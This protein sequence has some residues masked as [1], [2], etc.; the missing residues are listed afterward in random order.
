MNDRRKS[1]VQDARDKLRKALE[2]LKDNKP[3]TAQK[4]VESAIIT[5][6]AC[7]ILWDNA[8]P[9]TEQNSSGDGCIFGGNKSSSID[10]N[11]ST[12]PSKEEYKKRDKKARQAGIF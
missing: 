4:E 5:L 12:L 2:L 9:K 6:N 10:L 3:F 8:G 7:L 1:D 11:L